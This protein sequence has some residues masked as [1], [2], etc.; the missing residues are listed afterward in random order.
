MLAGKSDAQTR[1]IRLRNIAEDAD[2]IDALNG[3]QRRCTSCGRRLHEIA[4]IDHPLRD[5]AV[6]R[7]DDLGIRERCSNLICIGDGEIEIGRC[8]RRVR[9]RLLIGLLRR[10]L[11][12]QQ[13]LLPLESNLRECQIGAL[14]GNRRF[15]LGKFLFGLREG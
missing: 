8:N 4:A 5:H 2:E 3:E 11:D 15:G 13:A 7:G 6:K 1:N 14:R 9:L 12:S 10:A